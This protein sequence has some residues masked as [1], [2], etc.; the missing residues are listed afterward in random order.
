[1]LYF[2]FRDAEWVWRNVNSGNTFERPFR[3][4]GLENPS[5]TTELYSIMGISSSSVDTS[6]EDPA[7][8]T[9]DFSTFDSHVDIS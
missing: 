8:L 9:N 6:N 7:N 5:T 2:Y 4:E 1:M 3:V